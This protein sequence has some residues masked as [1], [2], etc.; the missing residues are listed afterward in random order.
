MQIKCNF[1]KVNE[2]RAWQSQ[3]NYRNQASANTF[4]YQLEYRGKKWRNAYINLTFFHSEVKQILQKKIKICKKELTY[5]IQTT[6][7]TI[8]KT[9]DFEWN[10]SQRKIF[11]LRFLLHTWKCSI[12]LK[13][14]TLRRRGDLYVC[15]YDLEEMMKEP[16]WFSLNVLILFLNFWQVH[17]NL[18]WIDFFFL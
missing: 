1:S 16:W 14:Q 18:C 5:K 3:C 17:E 6:Q 9:V 10:P 4:Y 7:F 8:Q 12:S 11:F 13:K 2:I 15:I